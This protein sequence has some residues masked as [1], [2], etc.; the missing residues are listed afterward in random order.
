VGGSC[1]GM[2]GV[3]TS[4]LG[5]AV[6]QYC[7]SLFVFLQ[8]NSYASAVEFASAHKK[9]ILLKNYFLVFIVYLMSYS[10]KC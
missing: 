2:T 8:L 3:L 5:T 4:P 1:E 9:I 6:F 10:Q 7:N